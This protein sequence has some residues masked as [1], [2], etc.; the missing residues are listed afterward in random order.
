M[1]SPVRHLFLLLTPLLLVSMGSSALAQSKGHSSRSSSSSAGGTKPDTCSTLTNEGELG[2]LQKPN[3]LGGTLVRENCKNGCIT[4]TL[5]IGDFECKTL[6][7]PWDDNLPNKS[8]IP[9]KKTPYLCKRVSSPK[10]DDTFQVANV[11]GRK[12]ILFHAGNFPAN[13]TGCVLL[14]MQVNENNNLVRSRDAVKAFL[15]ELQGYNEFTLT[16]IDKTKTCSSN[17]SRSV[18][19]R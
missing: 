18:A 5:K 6:E 4:G 12:H 8:C 17:S 7:L 10:F 14:G 3:T 19:G 1:K 16:I 9:V 2:S 15:G 11:E 13:T